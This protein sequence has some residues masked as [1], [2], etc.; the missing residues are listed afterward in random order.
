MEQPLIIVNFS[1]KVENCGYGT[2]RERVWGKM[3]YE[4]PKSAMTVILFFKMSHDKSRDIGWLY[5]GNL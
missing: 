4:R 2:A 3:K 5:I 1:W